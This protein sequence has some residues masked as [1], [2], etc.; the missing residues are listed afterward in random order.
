MNTQFS[1]FHGG[2]FQLQSKALRLGPL[3]GELTVVDGPVWL[4][5]ANDLGDHWLHA[6]DTVALGP[7]ADAV[8]EPG[9]GDPSVT[10]H[11]QPRRRRSLVR[12]AAPAIVRLATLMGQWARRLEVLARANEATTSPLRPGRGTAW[13]RTGS[14]P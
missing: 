12:W 9:R 11:W 8:I 4:T 7:D 1:Y 13:T 2:T 5:Q 6:G 3:A 10:V 14:T